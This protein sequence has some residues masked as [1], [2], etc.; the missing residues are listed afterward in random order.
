[1]VPNYPDKSTATTIDNDI[2]TTSGGVIV[3]TGRADTDISSISEYLSKTMESS[4]IAVNDL[5][6]AVHKAL[7]TPTEQSA[8]VLEFNEFLDGNIRIKKRIKKRIRCY[9]LSFVLFLVAFKGILPHPCR[10]IR[11]DEIPYGFG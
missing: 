2:G 9:F 4:V 10:D 7:T 11:N 8:L 6:N 1:M 5:T 3:V